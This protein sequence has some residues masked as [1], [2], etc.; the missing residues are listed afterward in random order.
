MKFTNAYMPEVYNSPKKYAALVHRV[1][2][3]IQALQKKLGFDALA[4]TGTSGAAIAYPVSVITGI[5]LICVRKTT[6]GSHCNMV[7]EGPS[8][9]DIKKYLI[10]DDFIQSGNT[11]RKII[12]KI[13]NN[14][15]KNDFS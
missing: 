5:P 12:K 7:V 15:W 14:K 3:K 1:A 6:R 4:F 13:K 11:I 9:K 8:D 10:V 2:K